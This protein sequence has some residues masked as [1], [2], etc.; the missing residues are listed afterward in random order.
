[1]Q[2]VSGDT[3]NAPPGTATLVNTATVSATGDTGQPGEK[4]SATVTVTSPPSLALTTTPGGTIALGG[5]FTI[6]GTKYLDTT[7][8]GLASGE[9]G[10]SGVTIDLYRES[11]GTA[12]LQ[13]GSG[14]D[15]LVASTVTASNGTYNFT[16]STAGTY[17]VEESVPSG[18]IQTGGGPYGSAGN[19]YYTINPTSG[20]TYANNNFSD[21]LIPTCTPTSVSFKVTTPSGSSQTVTNL[22]GNTAQGDTVTVTFTVPSGMNDTLTLVSYIAP[23]SSFSDSTAYQQQIYQYVTKT[24]SP[25]PYS[26]SVQ[27]PKSYYQI[28]FVC[29]SVINQLE[30]SQ[31]NDAYGPDAAEILYHAEGRFISSDNGGT[32]CPN[33]MP[34]GTPLTPPTST[35]APAPALTDSAT[36]SGGMNPT[37]TITFTLY[38]PNSTTNVVY[39]DKVTISG[40]GTYTTAAGNNPGGYIPTQAGTYP[41]G[42]GL[43]R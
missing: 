24:Y 11:D 1:M 41:V 36:L 6:S 21:F 29:G 42:G 7:G 43:Q 16:L 14:G 5:S 30:P 17:Y 33:P 4:A 2:I 31:N 39:T 10:Q 13:V 22:A 27:I 38:S 19:T 18:Y 20:N 12:G 35:S 15:L 40:D 23:G 28:D 37:G 8:N 32:T 9:S 34:M 25:G 26:L 3:I